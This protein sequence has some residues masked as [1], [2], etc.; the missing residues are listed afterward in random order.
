MSAKDSSETAASSNQPHTR[1]AAGPANGPKK[2][3]D[4]RLSKYFMTLTVEQNV[5]TAEQIAEY[6]S[7][8]DRNA[9]SLRI[10]YLLT[11]D[12]TYL[13]ELRQHDNEPEALATLARYGEDAKQ[14]LVD[15]KKLA[16]LDPE[17][18]QANLL[19]AYRESETGKPDAAMAVLENITAS[20][21]NL[22]SDTPEN[23]SKLVEALGLMNYG[24]VEAYGY[25]WS[26]LILADSTNNVIPALARN[27]VGPEAEGKVSA[28]QRAEYGG[29]L[30]QFVQ[31]NSTGARAP[32]AM[33]RDIL[34]ESQILRALPQDLGYGELGTIGSR[35]EE[36][37]KIYQTEAEKEDETSFALQSASPATVDAF[38]GM[39]EKDGWDKARTW[40]LENKRSRTW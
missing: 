1:K 16:G 26:H 33:M 32:Y 9:T 23:I 7:K 14:A 24:K 5:V 34:N 15:A 29:K 39:A 30:L 40:L 13:S 3:V 8:V 35:R 21:Q 2:S 10:V 20:G 27:V 38:I 6:F 11:K 12:R 31:D 22:R 37:K 19:I 4:P 25:L 28:E 18:P 36:V 17:N